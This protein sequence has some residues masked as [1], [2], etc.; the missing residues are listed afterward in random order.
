ML[1]EPLTAVADSARASQSNPVAAAATMIMRLPTSIQALWRRQRPMATE[2]IPNASADGA[3]A[4]LPI[5][6]TKATA[7]IR[8][9]TIRGAR[10]HR[11]QAS[12]ETSSLW[13]RS[14]TQ[15][16]ATIGAAITM[17]RQ[18]SSMRDHGETAAIPR[19][20]RP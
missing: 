15:E 8:W 14:A 10:S 17:N 18:G 4:S 20:R 13:N 3:T 19:V 7:A 16:A 9:A 5:A 2:R 1:T 6:K 12:D 11:S